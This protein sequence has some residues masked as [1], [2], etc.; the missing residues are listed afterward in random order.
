LLN[1]DMRVLGE[2]TDQ[3]LTSVHGGILWVVR[4]GT[5]HPYPKRPCIGLSRKGGVASPGME[6]S[7]V[8]S[9]YSG[10]W[11]QCSPSVPAYPFRGV[12]LSRSG[13]PWL[14]E[15]RMLGAIWPTFSAV[16]SAM[17]PSP[18]PQVRSEHTVLLPNV[19]L[20]QASAGSRSS[21]KIC[22]H[23]GPCVRK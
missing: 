2:Q 14:L 16:P 20:S 18:I 8:S 17:A 3:L 21:I 15:S 19:G 9:R 12:T 10:L 11:R 22:V 23:A 13:S 5:L 4:E 7:E 6:P 1:G